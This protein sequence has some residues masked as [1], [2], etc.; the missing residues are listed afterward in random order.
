MGLI[1]Y[2]GMKANQKD[3]KKSGNTIDVSPGV[4]DKKAGSE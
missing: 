3:I 2:M 4:P 1:F